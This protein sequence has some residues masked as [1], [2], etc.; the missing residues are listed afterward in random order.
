MESHWQE[1]EEKAKVALEAIGYYVTKNLLHN[2]NQIDL[3]A[4]KKETLLTNRFV[5]ECKDY[6]KNISVE[7]IR[8]FAQV[9]FSIST[10]EKPVQGLYITNMGYTKEAKNF[11]ESLNI[12]LKT[13]NELF[14]LSFNVT[15]VV[16]RIVQKFV[17]DELSSKYI[18][19]SCQAAE[20]SSGTIY[21]PLEKFIDK[22]LYNTKRVGAIVL[23]N[24]GTGKTSFAKHYSYLLASRFFKRDDLYHALPIYIN[25]RDIN[26][27]D[28]IEKTLLDIL[29][30]AY[31]AKASLV[32]LKYWLKYKSTLIILDGFDEMA[33]KMDKFEIINSTNSLFSFIECYPAIKLILTCRTHFFKTQIE[34]NLFRDI[35]KLYIRDWGADE[36]RDYIKLSN[37]N[38]EEEVLNTIKNTYNLEELSKTPLF[39]DMISKTIGEIGDNINKSKLYKIYTD[40]WIKSQDYR[41]SIS[42]QDKIVFMEEL[43]FYFLSK[44]ISF[45]NYQR[46]PQILKEYF[47]LNDYNLLKRFDDD[48]RT[49]S[50]LVR[51]ETGDYY[52]AH[53]SFLEYFVSLKLAKEVKQN[54]FNNFS[55]D[56]LT[57]EITLFFSDY[58]ADESDFI[59]RNILRNSDNIVRA[60]FALVGGFITFSDNLLKSLLL[61]IQ[62][63]E[64]YLVKQ[65][66]IDSLS[67]LNHPKSIKELVGLSYQRDEIGEYSLKVLST[68]TN[69]KIV[70][71]RMLEVILREDDENKVS[72]CIDCLSPID[73]QIVNQALICF[74]K[75][76][77]WKRIEKII[78]SY[79]NVVLNRKV[80]ELTIFLPQ[81]KKMN[82]DSYNVH[83]YI[84]KSMHEVSEKF[85]SDIIEDARINRNKGISFDKNR[86]MIKRKY[87]FLY[88]DRVLHKAF[89]NLYDIK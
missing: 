40:H 59:I 78:I 88:N 61:A 36:L 62:T 39:L 41:S 27:L 11:A 72:I 31:N 71:D 21:K 5:V 34:E 23:G 85:S 76:K 56:N 3:Y 42:P 33:T 44:G 46:I 80:F 77:W 53:K 15:H 19:L 43:A 73:N 47:P 65:N 16:Q 22:F 45:I 10:K 89:V 54:K 2:G 37:P 69:N 63:D 75:L 30:N 17:D 6:N 8:N 84:E 24:F 83:S 82:K 74:V 58:F 38:N 1:F 60:N 20:Y 70:L 66:A 25:L 29:N 57:I 9:V 49:C 48:I 26:N 51:T 32:G 86:S 13:L 35:L 7:K 50:F 14:E 12:N 28:N 81:L 4:E 64:F 87:K 18:D 67:N 52:F 68:H 79:I 55:I